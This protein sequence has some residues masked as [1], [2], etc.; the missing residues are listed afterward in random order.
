ME[1][2]IYYTFEEKDYEITFNYDILSIH[3][4][5]SHEIYSRQDVI[6]ALEFIHSTEEYKELIAAGYTR[7]LKEQISEWRAHNVMWSW[8]YKRNRTGSVDL[9][10][11]ESSLRKFLY[12]I[13]ACLG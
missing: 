1:K 4:E 13:I 3:I 8:G 9:D 7:T 12:A 5:S 10:Q 6:N 11:G 2:K